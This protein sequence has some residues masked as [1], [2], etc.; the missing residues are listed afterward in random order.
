MRRQ[1]LFDVTIDGR[2]ITTALQP[3]LTSLS[4]TDQAGTHGDSASIQLDDTGGK[5]ALPRTGAKI[6]I[7]LGWLGGGVREVFAGTVD[8]VRSSGSRGGGSLLSITAKGFDA[9]GKAKEG[10]ERHFDRK[11]V[12]DI[13]TAAAKDAGITV[14]VDPEIASTIIEYID[15]RGESLLHFGQRLAR[16]VGASFRVQGEVAV[17]ARRASDY[18]PSIT[19]ARGVNL[20][21]WDIAPVVG[22]SI[23][24]KAQA[25]YFDRKTGK[26]EKVEVP[27]GLQSDAVFVRRELCEDKD[28]AERAAKA[29]AAI[30]KERTGEGSVTI[31]GAPEAIPDGLCVLSGARPGIDGSYRIKSVTHDV[32][33]GG[34]FT[35]TLELA[36][37]QGG[38]GT[39]T[40]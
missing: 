35:T 19:A 9:T 28:A 26:V 8:E 29:D 11:S 1:A 17:I 39:D 3:L 33:R 15:M 24:G 32:T 22:R 13:I 10:Q 6:K 37:P 14:D 5:I 38:A 40:R 12:K 30:S 23:Y 7:A 21:S 25:R 16:M 34:G 2:S 20:H 4:V 18:T 31:E 27:T 36:Q